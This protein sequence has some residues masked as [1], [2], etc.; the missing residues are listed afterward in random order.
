M[1]VLDTSYSIIGGWK[2]GKFKIVKPPGERGL[3]DKDLATYGTY[4]GNRSQCKIDFTFKF[5]N[6]TF[7]MHEVPTVHVFEF[8]VKERRFRW[9]RHLFQEQGELKYADY[10]YKL[11]ELGEDDI[12][13]LDR[14]LDGSK[15]LS[16]RDVF[17]N[18]AYLYDGVHKFGGIRQLAELKCI[19]FPTKKMVAETCTIVSKP[20]TSVKEVDELTMVI[21]CT[22]SV[23]KIMENIRQTSQYL[24]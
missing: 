4:T 16:E 22:A 21:L 2:S 9:V 14:V 19:E 7:V 10:L 1:P 13:L 6:E 23:L 8:S 5:A 20:I 11:Y 18:K 3:N 15:D 12:S 17:L 24:D